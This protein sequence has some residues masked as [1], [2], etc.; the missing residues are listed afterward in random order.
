MILKTK[1]TK[2]IEN[3]IEQI[4]NSLRIIK[5]NANDYN[6][7]NQFFDINSKN[8]KLEPIYYRILMQLWSKCC[9]FLLDKNVNSFSKFSFLQM[10]RD[11]LE[12][13][14]LLKIKGQNII[15]CMIGILTPFKPKTYQIVNMK[16]HPFYSNLRLDEYFHLYIEHNLKKLKCKTIQVVLQKDDSKE[17]NKY[18]SNGYKKSEKESDQ[19]A[20]IKNNYD[21]YYKNILKNLDYQKK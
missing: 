1:K 9:F 18:C 4:F 21:I 8:D 6:I 10:N 5:T 12:N 15:G 11:Q 14:P 13:Y 17:I 3:E 2:N 19:S 7:I 20:D 16:I